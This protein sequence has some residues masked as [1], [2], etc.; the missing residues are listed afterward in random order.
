MTIPI[1]DHSPSSLSS[2]RVKTLFIAPLLFF[3]QLSFGQSPKTETSIT[4]LKFIDEY[5]I[6]FNFNYKG[7]CIG[8]LSGI[9]F[10]K[11]HNVYYLLSDDR[12]DINPVRFYTAKI[13]LSNNGITA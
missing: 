9:D 5:V 4:S 2:S 13:N 3:A 6:P 12:S 10:D 8:G 1:A 7:T 11:E